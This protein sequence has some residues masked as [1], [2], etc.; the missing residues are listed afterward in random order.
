MIYKKIVVLICMVVA[1]SGYKKVDAPYN[2]QF[3]YDHGSHPNYQV[4]WWYLTGHLSDDN[5]NE[6]NYG[7][8]FT[9]FRVGNSFNQPNN[10][11]SFSNLF[12]THFTI[13]DDTNKTFNEYDF[14]HREK[15]VSFAK[16]GHL[17]I[18]NGPFKLSEINGEFLIHATKGDHELTLNLKNTKPI[19][20]HGK[21]GYHKKTNDD[22]AASYYY[23]MTRLKGSGELK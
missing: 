20:F 13:T 2:W 8:E 11:W 16:E 17:N 12:I 15:D 23:S 21:N 4:E 14:T 22:H 5:S 10:P 7:F 6:Y 18:I 19:V 3:P 1:I 9:I